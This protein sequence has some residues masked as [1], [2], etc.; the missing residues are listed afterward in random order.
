MKKLLIRDSSFRQL[1]SRISTDVKQRYQER[2]LLKA[3]RF[4]MSRLRWSDVFHHENLQVL[5]QSV[6]SNPQPSMVSGITFRKGTSEDLQHFPELFKWESTRNTHEM[7][8]EK[9]DIFVVAFDGD[10]LIGIYLAS[11]WNA[12]VIPHESDFKAIACRFDL[13]SGADAISHGLFV[14]P[15]YRER[16]IGAQLGIH[17]SNVLAEYACQRVFSVVDVTNHASVRTHQKIGRD[18]ATEMISTQILNLCFI[19]MNVAHQQSASQT[20]QPLD[21]KT[22]SEMQIVSNPN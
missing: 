15:D 13:V 6:A 4:A 21:S 11:M 3:A 19:R 17:L 18:V 1:L 5:S 20:F 9:G 12:D 14:S 16:G 22:T 8:V 10:R 7:M 2:G